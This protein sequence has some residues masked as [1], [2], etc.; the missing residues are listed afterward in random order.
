MVTGDVC[1]LS[2]K[3]KLFITVCMTLTAA[4]SSVWAI[5]SLQEASIAAAP[6][7]NYSWDV[8]EESAEYFLREHSGNIGVY[9][10]RRDTEPIAVTDIE[11]ITLR[12]A[13]KAMIEAGMPVRDRD[14]L[15]MLLEDLGS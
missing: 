1:K 9:R 12:V 7:Y 4:A 6:R 8:P 14:E 10:T 11:L 2:F 3:T 13:D 5:G 15:L